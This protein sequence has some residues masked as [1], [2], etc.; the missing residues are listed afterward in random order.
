MGPGGGG[1]DGGGGLPALPPRSLRRRR[2]SAESDRWRIEHFSSF[3]DFRGFS[4]NHSLGPP[5]PSTSG[6]GAPPHDL[7]LTVPAAWLCAPAPR[8]ERTGGGRGAA[9]AEWGRI[10]WERR[11]GALEGGGRGEGPPQ[12]SEGPSGRRPGWESAEAGSLG[13]LPFQ[14]RL[15]PGNPALPSPGLGPVPAPNPAAVPAS[16]DTLLQTSLSSWTPWAIFCRRH[17]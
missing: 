12:A 9:W 7:A 8:T 16:C 17:C 15:F 1:G 10:G 5:L 3:G 2:R 4:V 11:L 6:R 13:S 14:E